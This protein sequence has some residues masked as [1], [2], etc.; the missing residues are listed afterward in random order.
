[1]LVRTLRS[2]TVYMGTF[3]WVSEQ[4]CA[5][6]SVTARACVCVK[7]SGCLKGCEYL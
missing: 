2:H 6:K 1:M 7:A 3:T 4:L 5:Y